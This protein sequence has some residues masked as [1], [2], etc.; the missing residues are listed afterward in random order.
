[1]I[2]RMKTPYLAS[3]ATAVAVF[4]AAPLQAQSYQGAD[5]G[6]AGSAAEGVS[7]GGGRTSIDP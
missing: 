6:S 3:A 1:M 5:S 4:G 2:Y 7:T